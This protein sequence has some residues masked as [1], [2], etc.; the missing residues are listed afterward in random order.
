M[1]SKYLNYV[2]A[3]VASAVMI[4]FSPQPEKIYAQTVPLDKECSIPALRAN[5]L[6]LVANV[7]S[8]K[9]L[10][11][12]QFYQELRAAQNSYGIE[13]I[14]GDYIFSLSVH[15]PKTGEARDKDSLLIVFNHKDRHGKEEPASFF[16]RG[17]DGVVDSAYIPANLAGN[18]EKM[19]FN[20]SSRGTSKDVK[21]LQDI[22]GRLAARLVEH[23][24]KPGTIP[25][26]FEPCPD[27]KP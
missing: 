16:D 5:L 19:V 21:H 9:K 20:I 12:S 26:G 1:G 2:R 7:A 15:K 17:I 23:Y 18:R 14:S 11:E 22:Y 24:R 6:Q 10:P 8:R 25:L 27:N 4:G 3:A 13:F